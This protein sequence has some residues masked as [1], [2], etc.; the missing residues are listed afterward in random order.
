M[1]VG[2]WFPWERD[3][4][5]DSTVGCFTS[6]FGLSVL[7]CDNGLVPILGEGEKPDNLF[8]ALNDVGVVVFMDGSSSS[9]SFPSSPSVIEG[10]VE[11]G[12]VEIWFASIFE[13]IFGK[14]SKNLPKSEANLLSITKSQQ[15]LDLVLPF[16]PC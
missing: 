10:R 1:S 4:K 7:D 15:N 2:V 12:S 13:E 6:D 11:L 14:K 16:C 3:S 8:D 9:P 5:S